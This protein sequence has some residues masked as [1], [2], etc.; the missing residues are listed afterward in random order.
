MSINYLP[1]NFNTLKLYFYQMSDS[2][3]FEGQDFYEEI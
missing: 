3:D 2:E 1:I